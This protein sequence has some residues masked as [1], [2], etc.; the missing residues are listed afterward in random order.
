LSA[1][2]T[3]SLKNS[4]GNDEKKARK[5]KLAYTILAYIGILKDLLAGYI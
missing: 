1:Y 4:T 5:G 2:G 3:I